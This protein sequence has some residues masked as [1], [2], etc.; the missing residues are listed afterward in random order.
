[1]RTRQ[2]AQALLLNSLLI[3]CVPGFSGAAFDSP[4]PEPVSFALA[5]LVSFP[6]YLIE[7]RKRWSLQT[8][9]AR[10]YGMA[11]IQPFGFR[12]SGSAL[13]GFL[14]LRGYGLKSGAYQEASTGLEYQRIVAAALRCGLEAE[15]MQVSI[16]DYGSTW[17]GQVNGRLNWLMPDRFA[18]AFTWIN[19]TG[20]RFG[21]GG[22]PLPRRLVLGGRLAPYQVLT[23][24]I[25]IEKDT[26]Y[27]LTSR[28]GAGFQPIKHITLLAGFQS[29]PNLASL[30]FSAQIGGV[31]AAA[32]YQY[33]ADLGFSQ[34]YGIGVS[35]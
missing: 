32:A 16:R 6:D 8:G 30:G 19:V 28:L 18:L 35:F 26:R 14:R 12:A 20:S 9:G 3:V 23:L 2:I 7:P 34:C 31:R 29:D 11:E 13:G 1:M 22:Y 5:G 24:F 4:E 10:L 15:V 27:D 33:Q 17:T 25:E 21:R